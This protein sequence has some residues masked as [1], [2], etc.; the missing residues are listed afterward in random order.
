MRPLHVRNLHPRYF[1][2][3]WLHASRYRLAVACCWLTGPLQVVVRSARLLCRMEALHE[4]VPSDE[5]TEGPNLLGDLFS[6]LQQLEVGALVVSMSSPGR[7]A[8]QCLLCSGLGT[9]AVCGSLR[10]ATYEGQPAAVHHLCAVWS[11]LHQLLQCCRGVCWRWRM[12]RRG[13]RRCWR[14]QRSRAPAC[15]RCGSRLCC[16]THSRWRCRRCRHLLDRWVGRQPN[17]LDKVIWTVQPRDNPG[18]AVGCSAEQ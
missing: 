14:P 7:A 6:Y 3:S 18:C 2:S 16:Q 17:K 11:H 8:P 4:V 12:A 5:R 13:R 10:P 9:S 1:V 15:L